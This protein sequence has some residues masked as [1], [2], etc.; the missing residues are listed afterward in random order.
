MQG[1]WSLKVVEELE[2]AV[3][4]KSFRKDFQKSTYLADLYRLSDNYL[5]FYLKYIEP[6]KQKILKGDFE[7]ANPANVIHWD[8]IMGLQFENLVIRNRKEL[9]EALRI[10]PESCTFDGPFFQTKTADRKGCQIDYLI[11]EKTTLFICEIKFSKNPIG[12]QV[13]EEVKKKI[14]ALAIPKHISLR[15]VLIHVG[16]VMDEVRYRDYFDRVIDWTE[17]L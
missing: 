3:L 13:I 7:D 14:E 12:T 10:S 8:A 2:K 15:P 4:L 6:N 17:L 16:G 1:L 9:L 5:R 11:Q